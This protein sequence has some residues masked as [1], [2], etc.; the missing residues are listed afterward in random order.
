MNRGAGILLIG[1]LLAAG[2]SGCG[3]KDR[4][5]AT[6]RLRL[7]GIDVA[8]A[9]SSS[10]E[11][12]AEV[13]GT[14]RSAKIAVLAARVMGRITSIPVDE[15]TRVEAGATLATIDDAA[16][17]AQW[18][19]AESAVAEAEAGREEVERAIAQ[20]QAGNT[21]A[22]KTFERYRSLFAEKIVTAQEFDEIQAKRTVAEQEYRRSLDRK[23][24]VAARLAQAKAQADAAKTMLSYT[25]ITAP[26]AGVV[27]EK[28]ADAGSMA[29][30]G[31]P[32]LVLEDPSRYRVE[33]S[34][35]ESF[36]GRLR[37]GSRVTVVLDA[38]PVRRI[39]GTVSET[40]PRVDPMSRT[41]VAKVDLPGGRGLRTG[42]SGKVRFATGRETVVT[43]PRGAITRAAGY[44]GLF[45]VGKDNV[46]RLALVT[47]GERFGDRVEILSGIDPGT[48]VVVSPPE[49]L[50]DGVRV[51]IRR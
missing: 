48:R 39:A 5:P 12:T 28:R 9:E 42:M 41:F 14:V 2:G 10:R 1:I 43:V 36:L 22:E 8:I 27:T 15:G 50:A 31:M 19:A 3:G 7:S 23:A 11:R 49:A 20:A 45:L 38:D 35:P 30:P 13:T 40:I 47:P 6:E 37:T 24:Q 25:R 4:E 26:F 44:E 17:R 16:I 33:A 46:A 32:I 51:E 21:L 34:V 18:V 29:S